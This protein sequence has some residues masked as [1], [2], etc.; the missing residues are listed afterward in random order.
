MICGT[1]AFGA[2]SNG[3]FCIVQGAA[4][5]ARWEIELRDPSAWYHFVVAVDTNQATTADRQVLYIN[6][7]QQGAPTGGLAQF[8]SLIHI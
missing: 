1:G 5:A 7:V 6:G 8:L 4:V 2:A 3:K